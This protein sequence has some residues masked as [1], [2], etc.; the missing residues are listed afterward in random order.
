VPDMS[1]DTTA[2]RPPA[3][4]HTG[5]TG[6]VIGYVAVLVLVNVMVDTVLASPTFVLPQLRDA[7]DTTQFAWLDSS[8]MLAGAMWAPPSPPCSSPSR[9]SGTSARPSSP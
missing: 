5:W 7:F 6:R 4:L 2:Q 1:S 8:A 3:D 9:S